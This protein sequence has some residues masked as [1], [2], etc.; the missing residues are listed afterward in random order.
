M[1]DEI[2]NNQEDA[3]EKI[4][5]KKEVR[6]EEQVDKKQENLDT[7][8]EDI[9]S[10]GDDDVP[11]ENSNLENPSYNQGKEKP[12]IFT[13]VKKDHKEEDDAKGGFS[14]LKIFIV[15]ILIAIFLGVGY[16]AY[17][18]YFKDMIFDKGIIE[19]D[20]YIENVDNEDVL[21]DQ[22]ENS[23]ENTTL[24]NE[25]PEKDNNNNNNII[26][27]EKDTDGDGLSDVMERSLGLNINNI[28]TD[29][30]G[31]FDREEV[32]VYKTDPKNADTDGDSFSDGDEVK[33]GYN[34]NGEGKLY[35]INQ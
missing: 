31:L 28:D 19:N 17:T 7:K 15:I 29:G 8:V 14:F 26:V 21:I 12:A 2:N 22:E 34:P 30:D 10:D 25:Q 16:L 13:P 24:E 5:E 33:A 18:K 35:N 20:N 9:F 4:V 3:P 11:L 32:E 1:F 27:N 6:E 23:L